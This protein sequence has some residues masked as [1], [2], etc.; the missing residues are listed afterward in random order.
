[1]N[2]AFLRRV[3]LFQGL[4]DPQLADVLMLGAVKD[5]D[6]DAVLFEEG[7]DGDRLYIVYRGTVRISRILPDAG[8]EALAL[9]GPGE[10][11]GEMSFFDGEP[12]SARAIAHEP[13]TV[14]E[15][16][17]DELKAHLEAHPDVALR[18]LAAFCRTLCR[19]VRETNAKFSTLFAI[20]RVF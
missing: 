7:S 16:Q 17:N 6:K 15:I 4:S 3:P 10:F 14:L 13:T 12:R 20:A 11:L 8:E 1:M 5:Y 19:R 2:A 18:F 9:A